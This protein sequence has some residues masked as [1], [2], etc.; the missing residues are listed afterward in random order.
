MADPRLRQMIE[1]QQMV[2]APGVFDMMAAHIANRIGFDAV[3]ASGYW[4]TASYL[5]IPDAGIATFTDMLNRVS[6]LC[7]ISDAPVVADADTGYGGLLNLHHTVKGYEKA[8]VSGFQ[9]E[10]QV[11]PKKCG[12][13]KNRMVI[14]LEEMVDKIKV[15]LDARTD[16]NMLLIARTD[17]RT[18]YGLDVALERGQAFAEAG[19]D[20]VFVEALETEEEMRKATA[21]IG[22]PMMAN[23]ADGGH[24][25]I[26]SGDKLQEIGYSLAIFPAITALSAMAA[27]ESALKHIK[28]TGTSQGSPVPRFDF[29]EM[30][31]LLGF[32]DVW[33]FEKRWGIGHQSD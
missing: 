5:G 19:A 20:L 9:F 12:H 8:G 27:V 6:R 4:L 15:A 33:D 24:T 16:S 14:P 10:D 11:F 13:T 31:V 25:P 18:D 22:H 32:E 7:E 29:Q 21:T 26:F 30:C 3:Y 23:M 1:N 2:V 28:A 17:A